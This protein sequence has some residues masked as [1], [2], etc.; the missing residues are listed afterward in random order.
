MK[1]NVGFGFDIHRLEKGRKLHLGGVEIPH[2]A[3]LAG[4][5]DGD[6]LIHALIDALL[7]AAGEG[8]IGR[9]FPV[10]DSRYLGIRSTRLLEDVMKRLAGKGVRIVNLDSVI[11]AET[12]RLAPYIDK[13]KA[14]LCPILGVAE[15]DLGIKAKTH[16]KMGDIGRG[17]AIACWAVALVEVGKSA[18]SRERG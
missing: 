7:G 2:P 12:P 11:V 6:A 14:V 8:D 10:D 15:D 1:I 18:K 16:E 17:K 5:S 4:Q 9:L 3:G 13:M